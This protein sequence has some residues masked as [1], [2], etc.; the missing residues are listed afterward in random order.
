M[1]VSLRVATLLGVGLEFKGVVELLYVLEGAGADLPEHALQL[2][3]ELQ[4]AQ[5]EQLL[6]TVQDA[7]SSLNERQY[8]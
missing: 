5:R 7:V 4:C 6:Y 1:Y 2:P 8:Q 3:P